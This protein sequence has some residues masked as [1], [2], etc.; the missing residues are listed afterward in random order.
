[1]VCIP[2]YLI[3]LPKVC[4]VWQ[5]ALDQLEVVKRVEKINIINIL[6]KYEEMT[7]ESPL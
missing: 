1:M 5:P 7:K 3:M 2:K 4:V 6:V